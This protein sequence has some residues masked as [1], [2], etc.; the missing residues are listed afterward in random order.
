MLD[1]EEEGHKCSA[2]QYHI[3]FP[4]FWSEPLLCSHGCF[5]SRQRPGVLGQRHERVH[6]QP[7][8]DVCGRLTVKG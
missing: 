2:I 4:G 5:A 8:R 7:V 3:P 6:S 1:I